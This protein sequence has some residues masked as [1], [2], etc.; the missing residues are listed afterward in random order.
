[1][2]AD[3]SVEEAANNLNVQIIASAA[4]TAPAIAHMCAKYMKQPLDEQN[5]VRSELNH[6][7]KKWTS[8]IPPALNRNAHPYSSALINECLRV[9]PPAAFFREKVCLGAAMQDPKIFGDQ[10]DEF[11][12]SRWLK[13]DIKDLQRME[14]FLGLVLGSGMSE[15]LGKR[16]ALLE[17]SRSLYTTAQYRYQIVNWAKFARFS[18]KGV[19]R[20]TDMHVR[21]SR[22]G[23]SITPGLPAQTLIGTLH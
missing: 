13:S 15:C 10:A 23:D 7:F 6:Y 5:S 3:L 16:T 18:N 4:V 17:M 22:L 14:D 8:G 19:Q 2:D 12:L 21:V 1:M 9:C 20:V 11:D